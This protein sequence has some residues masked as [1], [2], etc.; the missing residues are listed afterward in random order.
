M[1]SGQNGRDHSPLTVISVNHVARTRGFTLV[2]LLVV[3]AII[4]VLVALL[5][6]AVQSAREAA[7]RIAVPQQPQAGRPGHAQLRRI[8]QRLPVGTYG[9]CWGTWQVSILPY[10]E[11][12]HLADLYTM[13]H[14]FGVPVDDT[15]LQ[16]RD[17]F[18][19]DTKT[20]KALTCPSDTSPPR[21]A[22][23]GITY[24]NYVV[25]FGNTIYDQSNFAGV[26]FLG[27]PFFEVTGV[28]DTRPGI[29][30][31]QI[32]DGLSNTLMNAETVQGQAGDLRGFSWWRGGAVFQ[33]YQGPNSADSRLPVCRRPMRP[34]PNTSIHPAL[35]P[36]RPRPR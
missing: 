15:A 20:F 3:I 11:Q 26:T 31:A 14:M 29:R 13:R 8:L 23:N 18:S 22:N 21:T 5:L 16:P 36:P 12:R 35:S 1:I 2:E 33:G 34:Q 9:C 7:R 6:P 10:L 30:F 4:G 25:N 19:R 17:Q 28:A 27:A 32:T 24:H